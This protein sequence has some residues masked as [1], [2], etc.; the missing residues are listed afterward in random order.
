MGGQRDALLLTGDSVSTG[1]RRRRAVGGNRI[2]GARSVWRRGMRRLLV[3]S[4]LDELLPGSLRWR[5]GRSVGRGLSVLLG[6]TGLGHP[7][8]G[9]PVVRLPILGLPILG[10][11]MLGLAVLGLPVLR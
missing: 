7:G 1:M 9:L 4:G 11:P 8:L 3:W 5:C 2:R 6:A 10:L